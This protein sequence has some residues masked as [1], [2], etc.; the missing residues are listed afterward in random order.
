MMFPGRGVEMNGI[1]ERYFSFQGR[2]GR[3]PYFIRS[4]QLGIAVSV[5]FFLSIPAFS[6]G[7]GIL[8]G[9]GL[10]LVV[11]AGA[12]YLGGVASLIVRRLHDLGLSGYHAIW[13]V[14]ASAPGTAATYSHNFNVFLLNLPFIAV[15][16]WILFWP[17]Q[18]GPNRFGE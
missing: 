17:G 12:I 7:N 4:V 9:I 2:L 15:G 8:W 13:V 11:V 3:L 14:I 6:N 5:I 16:L 10:L 1:F 18:R